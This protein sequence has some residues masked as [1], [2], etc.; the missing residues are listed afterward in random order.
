VI[1]RLLT[2]AL[3]LI[4]SAALAAGTPAAQKSNKHVAHDTPDQLRARAQGAGGGDRARLYMEA[5]T[6]G[7]EEASQQFDTGDPDIGQKLVQDA[8]KD[9]TE[10]ANATIKSGDRMKHTEIEMRKLA[11]RLEDVEHSVSIE[12]RPAVKTAVEKLHDLD[13][14]I[15]DRMFHKKDKK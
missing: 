10:A 14:A 1:R 11:R 12:D 13:R 9:A 15:L 5:A 7:V 3:A 2:I 6:E 8:V 4:A